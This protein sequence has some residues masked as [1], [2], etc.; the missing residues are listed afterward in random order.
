ML[1][2]LWGVVC[3]AVYLG[4]ATAADKIEP[5]PP[6]PYEKAMDGASDPRKPEAK[7]TLTPATMAAPAIWLPESGGALFDLNELRGRQVVL[8]FFQGM[9]CPH[10]MARLRELAAKMRESGEPDTMIVAV[11]GQ[12]IANGARPRKMLEVP[13][14]APFRLLID[15]NHTAFRDFNCFDDGTLHGLF[16]IDDSATVRYRYVGE[17]PFNNPEA[18]LKAVSEV[19]RAD[20]AKKRP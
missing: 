18:V 3:L 10:C 16:V 9:A 6:G 2:Y 7:A 12:P 15:K 14:G 17:S 5:R 19:K 4:S 13:E 1:L 11:S 20:L 8:V